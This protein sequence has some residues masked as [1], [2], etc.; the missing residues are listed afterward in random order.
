LAAG[1]FRGLDI[2]GAPFPDDLAVGIPGEDID[3]ETNAGAVQVFDGASGGLQ[4]NADEFIW[5]QSGDIVGVAEANDRFGEVLTT[6]DFDADQ[7]TD[8]VVS[9]P[10]EDLEGAGVNDA[11]AVHVIYGGLGGL[12]TDDNRLFHQNT[13]GIDGVAENSDRFGD[14]L[15]GGGNFGDDLNYDLYPDLV[16]GIPREND[17]RGAFLVLLGGP[18]G[19][20]AEDSLF[21][22]NSLN[23][24]AILDEMS[25][26][27]TVAD[28][29]NGPE[30]AVSLPGDDFLGDNDTGSVIVYEFE[31][32]DVIFEDSFEN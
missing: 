6:G 20:T 23:S 25:F 32:P 21:E 22:V 27:M 15:V 14:S 4:D 8:L 29:G 9:A 10:R 3:G 17:S 19:L 24:D 7:F 30:L 1:R 28:F 12:S 11:G 26:A 31:N 16:I 18:I 2:F 13:T 5:S